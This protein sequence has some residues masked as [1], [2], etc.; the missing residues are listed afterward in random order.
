MKTIKQLDII[1][2]SINCVDAFGETHNVA[3][4][5][6]IKKINEIVD[7][8]NDLIFCLDHDI[9]YSDSNSIEAIEEKKWIGKLCWFW[10]EE[11]NTKNIVGFLTSVDLESRRPFCIN[12]SDHW[13]RCEPVRP[14]DNVIYEGA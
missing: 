11:F 12:N 10:N 5:N 3:S 9:P 8:L 7:A 14:D 2:D 4:F 1:K 6:A 13:E